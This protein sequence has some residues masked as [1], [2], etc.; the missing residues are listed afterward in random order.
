MSTKR[1]SKIGVT[2]VRD[3]DTGAAHEIKNDFIVKAFFSYDEE[4]PAEMKVC[5]CGKVRSL[6]DDVHR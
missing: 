1:S 3:P 6:S 2:T 4:N 5:Q